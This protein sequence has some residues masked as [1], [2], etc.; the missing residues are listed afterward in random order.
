[1]FNLN[2]LTLQ[3]I[4]QVLLASLFVFSGFQS[5]FAFNGFKSMITG[6]GF[7]VW[8]AF[9]ALA[10][11]LGGGLFLT[12]GIEE[13]N[14]SL[15]LIIFTLIASVLFHN[16]FPQLGGNSGEMTTFLRNLSIIGGLLMVLSKYNI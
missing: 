13:E 5:L 4:G 12:L 2:P 1:M 10:V 6:K 15:G 7:P 16:P 14:A 11:K 3:K 9:L 8:V